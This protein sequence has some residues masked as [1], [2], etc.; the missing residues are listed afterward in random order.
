MTAL[1]AS[2]GY[3]SAP[4]DVSTNGVVRF[5][6]VFNFPIKAASFRT[7]PVLDVLCS[8][9]TSGSLQLVAAD[10]SAGVYWFNATVP[11][12]WNGNFSATIAPDNRIVDAAYQWSFLANGTGAGI[13]WP[14]TLFSPTLSPS[15][16]STA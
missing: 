12:P 6:V 14:L 5:Y 2:V 16:A 10:A 11:M 9:C 15:V 13:A 3:L 1:S 8:G 4:S 7:Q